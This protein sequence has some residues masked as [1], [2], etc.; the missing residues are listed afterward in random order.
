MSYL[1]IYLFAALVVIPA[2]AI[3]TK[4][5]LSFNSAG[6][7]AIDLID[8]L[9]FLYILSWPVAALVKIALIISCGAETA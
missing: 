1:S 2:I 9:V 5:R 6:R 3:L 8:T 4:Y 7:G